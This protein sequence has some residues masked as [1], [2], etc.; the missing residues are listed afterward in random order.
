[1][2]KQAV[3]KMVR[4]NKKND[5]GVETEPSKLFLFQPVEGLHDPVNVFYDK[6]CS[7]SLFRDDLPGVQLR[8]TLLNKGP[9]QRGDVGA[10]TTVAGEE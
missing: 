1:M 6:E 9:F 2:I 8:G 7:E 4:L 5:P 3:R 10:L